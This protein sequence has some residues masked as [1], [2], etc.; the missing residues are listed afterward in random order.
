MILSCAH[1]HTPFCDG[2]TPMDDMA[3]AAYSRGFVSLG[4]S[5]HAPQSFDPP[6]FVPKEK[7]AEYIA[8]VGRLQDEYDGKMKIWLGCERDLFS[9][10]ETS[11]Y[12]YFI[13]SSHYMPIS[14]GFVEVD[15]NGEKLKKAVEK[16]FDG[17]GIAF[18]RRY[19]AAF[20][21]YIKAISP[22]IIGHFDIVR[23]NALKFQLFDETDPRYRDAALLNAC[24]NWAKEQGC[25]EFASD[26]EIDNADNLFF[27]LRL[28]FTEANRVICFTKRLDGGN[29]E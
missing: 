15:G 13:A 23:K 29:E 7:E 18:A 11:K 27:H 4:F 20:A 3:R 25:L 14:D 24:E 21:L 17:D 12:E 10:A 19:Y 22:T 26:C 28:G 9:C 1:T 2:K 6:Y 5:S 16:E 8:E